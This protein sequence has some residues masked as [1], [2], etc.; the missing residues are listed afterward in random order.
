MW[1]RDE[2]GGG[3]GYLSIVHFL[4]EVCAELDGGGEDD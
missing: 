4:Y 2:C 3:C 1:S